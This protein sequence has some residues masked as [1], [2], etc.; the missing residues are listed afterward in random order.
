MLPRIQDPDTIDAFI[1]A[2]A[3]AVEHH[4]IAAYGTARAWAEQLGF[5]DDANVLQ[6]TLD[7]ENRADKLLS[8]IA[9]RSVNE[10]AS[11]SADREVQVRSGGHADRAQSGGSG[12]GAG[13]GVES[14]VTR[15]ADGR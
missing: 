13:R 6:N 1:I 14:S 2:A 10:Q 12:S 11:D 4:E 3:Q 7:E 15:A 5:T 8:S 9:E